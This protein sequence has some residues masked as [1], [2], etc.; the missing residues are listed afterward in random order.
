MKFSFDALD[1]VWNAVSQQK[2]IFAKTMP[3]N[4]HWYTLRRDWGNDNLFDQTVQAIRDNGYEEYYGGRP[5]TLLDVNGMKYWTMG[6]PIG[7]TIL[8]N[9]KHTYVPASYDQVAS[10]Y[11]AMFSDPQSLEENE[12]VIKMLDYRPGESVLDIGC[13]TGLL[14]DYLDNITD[15]VGLD[16]SP[17][18][19]GIFSEKHPGRNLICSPFESFAWGNKFDLVVSLFASASYI[20]PDAVQRILDFVKPGGRWFVMFFKPG[21]HPVTYQRSGIEMSHYD[22]NHLQMPGNFIEFNNFVISTGR[23]EDLP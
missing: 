8:I 12:A 19:L 5:Y 14:L 2:W 9:R 21:Y 20:S 17:Q 1:N 3:D 18:M 7:E 11:D 10:Q 15:Y 4:P 16:P 13:G 22:N 6:A 23:Y